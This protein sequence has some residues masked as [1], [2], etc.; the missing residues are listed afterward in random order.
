M[1]IRISARVLSY[2]SGS[3]PWQGQNYS[4]DPEVE[5]SAVS[6][7]AKLREARLRADG[8]VAVELIGREHGVLY[9][10]ADMMSIQDDAGQDMDAL[11]DL[12][13][14]KALLR[15]LRGSFPG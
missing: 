3:S 9:D 10:Y 15:N 7:F 14:A 5:A 8:S 12:N 1:K 2:L 13:A 6:L 4:N 11:A